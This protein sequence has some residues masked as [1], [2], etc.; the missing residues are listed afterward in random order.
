MGSECLEK[1]EQNL[2]KKISSRERAG[3]KKECLNGSY[4]AP[5]AGSVLLISLGGWGESGFIKDSSKLTLFFLTA[6]R[7]SLRQI[8]Y[9]G[10]KHPHPSKYGNFL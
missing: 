4:L 7:E 9:I 6:P 8:W 2:Q 5:E 3:Q 1:E 10:V